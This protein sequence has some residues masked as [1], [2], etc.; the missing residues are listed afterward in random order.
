MRAVIATVTFD[1]AA[2]DPA[3]C[4]RIMSSYYYLCS[5]IYLQRIVALCVGIK[6]YYLYNKMK[7]TVVL[8]LARYNII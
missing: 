5:F 2:P 6:Y 4:R 1:S 8:Y 3:P 7:S